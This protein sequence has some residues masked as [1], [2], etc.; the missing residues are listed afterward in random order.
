MPTSQVPQDDISSYLGPY[1]GGTWIQI[2]APEPQVSLQELLN[3]CS[4]T[5][6]AW[7]LGRFN[8]FGLSTVVSRFVF[9]VLLL[10]GAQESAQCWYV[11]THGSYANV[12]RMIAFSA[13]LRVYG[14]NLTGGSAIS[15]GGGHRLL[16]RR[17]DYGYENRL[18]GT[19]ETEELTWPLPS[20]LSWL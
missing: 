6:S 20:N 4:W 11:T 10:G 19:K 15:E 18:A 13:G 17:S 2:A 12:M 8:F 7:L 1:I 9:R 14:D 16:R 5:S 3:M